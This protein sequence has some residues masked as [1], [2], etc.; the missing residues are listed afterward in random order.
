MGFDKSLGGHPNIKIYFFKSGC[1]PDSLDIYR[2][3]LP[4]QLRGH[5]VWAAE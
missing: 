1:G 2:V 4:G 5:Y 3:A